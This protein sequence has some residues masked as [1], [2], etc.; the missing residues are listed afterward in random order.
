VSPQALTGRTRNPGALPIRNTYD[1]CSQV[2]RGRRI[3][4]ADGTEQGGVLSSAAV[5]WAAGRADVST[6]TVS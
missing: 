3:P 2:F 1:S 6:N 4:S 5:V